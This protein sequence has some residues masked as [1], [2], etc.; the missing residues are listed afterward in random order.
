MVQVCN[1]EEEKVI[2]EISCVLDVMKSVVLSDAY[3][4]NTVSSTRHIESFRNPCK[5][6][7]RK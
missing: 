5:I 1:A 7:A 4:T 6:L 3:Q 2:L